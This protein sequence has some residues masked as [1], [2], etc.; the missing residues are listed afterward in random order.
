MACARAIRA[1]NTRSAPQASS[2]SRPRRPRDADKKPQRR[3][4]ADQRSACRYRNAIG[5]VAMRTFEQHFAV[6]SDGLRRSAIRDLDS[7]D[8]S[9]VRGT[10][11]RRQRVRLDVPQESSL[12]PAKRRAQRACR[13]SRMPSRTTRPP[14]ACQADRLSPSKDEA[15]IT[16]ATGW[17]S[18]ATEENAAGSTASA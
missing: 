12:L 10:R 13:H 14:S 18:S 9:G 7:G 11:S 2:A 8:Q 1:R 4:K 16:A 6:Q 17:I 3:D 15:K 5:S